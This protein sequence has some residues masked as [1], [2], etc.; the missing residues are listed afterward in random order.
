MKLIKICTYCNSNNSMKS[1]K[2]SSCNSNLNDLLY[3]LNSDNTKNLIT[4]NI[5]NDTSNFNIDVVGNNYYVLKGE[6]YYISLEFKTDIQ[7]I[8]KKEISYKFI[9]ANHLYYYINNGKYYIVDR[10]S[11][12]GTMLNNNLLEYNQEYEINNGDEI[13]LAD[14]YFKIIKL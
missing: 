14:L 7:S 8:G 11:T 6:N 10:S 2:C 13:V 12:N 9:S 3:N 5:I 1:T 4:S